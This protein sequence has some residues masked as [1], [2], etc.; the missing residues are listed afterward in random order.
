MT[1]VRRSFCGLPTKNNP[2]RKNYEE[3]PF[4]LP[5]SMG[6]EIV[7]SSSG[8]FNRG[9]ESKGDKNHSR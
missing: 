5:P 7:I 4:E 3:Q 6:R 2:K 1:M 9:D 8:E